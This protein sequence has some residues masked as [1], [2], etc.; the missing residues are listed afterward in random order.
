MARTG[1]VPR[2]SP[3]ASGPACR[4][5]A[6]SLTSPRD[7][8]WECGCGVV[9]CAQEECTDEYFRFIAGGEATRCLSCSAVL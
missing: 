9:V 1:D 2:P 4:A 8:G 5:C 3:V 6:R 7:V